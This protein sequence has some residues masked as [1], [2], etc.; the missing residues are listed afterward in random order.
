MSKLL[1]C[2]DIVMVLDISNVVNKYP[3]LG[4]MRPYIVVCGPY[5]DFGGV[6]KSGALL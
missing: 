3:V 1:G 6:G 5:A 2:Y 4:W